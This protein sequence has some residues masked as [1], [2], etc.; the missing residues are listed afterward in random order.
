MK[1][2]MSKPAEN[3]LHAASYAVI[4]VLGNDSMTMENLDGHLR[5]FSLGCLKL[6]PRT[7]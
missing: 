4:W 6:L 3:G 5:S 7:Y 1:G 2:A